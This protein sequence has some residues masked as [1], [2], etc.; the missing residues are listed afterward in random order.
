MSHLAHRTRL[1]GRTAELARLEAALV[2]AQEGHPAVA[3]VSGEAGVG[4]SR[5]VAEFVDRARVR[6]ATV[7][8][9]GCLELTD[10]GLPYGALAEALRS[11][12]HEHGL[13][14]LRRLAGDDL[15]E[16]TLIVP[17]LRPREQARVPVAAPPDASTRPRILH[18][19]LGLLERLTA[20]GPALLVIE[21]LHWSDPSTADL[22]RY[23]ARSMRRARLLVVATVRTGEAAARPL[24]ASLV[25]APNVERLDLTPFSREELGR[26]LEE[27]GGEPPGLERVDWIHGRTKGNAF[28]ATQLLAVRDREPMPAPLR[29]VLLV[30]VDLLSPPAIEVVQTLAVAGG[31]ARHDLIAAGSGLADDRLD[32][33]LREAIAGTAVV[34]DADRGTY[35]L[36][37]DLLVDAVLDG[38]LPGERARLHATLAAALEREPRLAVRSAPAE[39]ARHWSAAG[40]D[41]R[42]LRSSIAAARDAETVGGLTEAWGHLQRAVA[43]WGSSDRAETLTD[44]SHEGLLVWAAQL[45]HL[46]GEVAA[47]VELQQRVLDGAEAVDSPEHMLLLERL[48]RF[49]W[50]AGDSAGAEAAYVAA[51]AAASGGAATE[52][53]AR[54]LCGYSQLLMLAARHEET[55]QVATEALAAARAVGARDVEAN[56]LN[57]LGSSLA[58]RGQSSG[59]GLL[60]EARRI[61]EENGAPDDVLRAWMNLSGALLELGRFEEVIEVGLD[62]LDRARALGVEGL[63][64]GPLSLNVATAATA[65]GRWNLADDVLRLAPLELGGVGAGW[66]HVI[67]AELSLHRG[68]VDAARAQ[69]AA[70]R[71]LR[72]HVNE[73]AWDAYLGV[74]AAI[75]AADGDVARVGAAARKRKSGPPEKRS[76]LELHAILIRALGTSPEPDVAEV[77]ATLADARRLAA[78]LGEQAP[79]VATWLAVAEAEA[80]DVLDGPARSVSRWREALQRLDADGL[81]PQAAAARLRLAEALSSDGRSPREAIELAHAAHAAAS[82][83]GAEPLRRRCVALARRLGVDV[84][85][86]ADVSAMPPDEARWTREGAVWALAYAG[87]TVRLPDAKGLA[88]LAVLLA[89]PGRDVAATELIGAEFDEADVG[90]TIDEQARRA[91]EQRIRTLQEELDEA[92]AFGDLARADRARGELDQLVDALTAATGLRGRAR[93]TG[94]TAEK[95]RSAVTHR[96][97]ETIRRVHAA[98]HPL[99][100]HLMGSVRTGRW[101]RYEPDADAPQWTVHD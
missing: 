97:R 72:V 20:D 90:P 33:A 37:H 87:S 101:C 55:E 57:N 6:G 99:G 26:F 65:I 73:Q 25:A 41:E 76:T 17:E 56:A 47:A 54:V 59:V 9:G 44:L 48:G 28:L 40:D 21:D 29:D 78:Q 50:D 61:A 18:S 70:A 49:R 2:R 38:M 69:L 71:T 30:N 8:A 19:L 46:S 80:T 93:R 94:G 52:A 1:V 15:P 60:R 51:V 23:I 32:V 4:K 89:R 16:L 53:R 96:I 11:F 10:G 7:L 24:I 84:R 31:Q 12:A 63:W 68:L 5:L 45:A 13:G 83:L 79:L 86:S 75:A 36:R 34:V 58:M 100:E 81:R 22:L 95:A 77:T 98:H 62:G 35:A 42:A 74:E 92:T 85:V 14:P 82:E 43:L 66:T 27:L 3:L 64:G 88:D 91:Y 67:R 39:L